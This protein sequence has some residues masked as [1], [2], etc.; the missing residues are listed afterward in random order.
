MSLQAPPRLPA[1]VSHL[2]FRGC[3]EA[4]ETALRSRLPFREGDVLT[5]ELLE[6]ARHAAKFLDDHLGIAIAADSREELLRIPAELRSAS[7]VVEG[8]VNLTVVDPTSRPRRVRVSASDQASMLVEK[9]LPDRSD[10]AGLVNLAIVVGNDGAVIDSIPLAGPEPLIPAALDA[11]SRWRYR[12]M[13]L[14]GR[15][16]EV[17]TTVDVSFPRYPLSSR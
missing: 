17:Q 12:P 14:N 1:P 15:P 10:I 3:S 2:F 13:L 5:D 4:T 7:T 11:V 16:V 6:Q 8:G 9:V